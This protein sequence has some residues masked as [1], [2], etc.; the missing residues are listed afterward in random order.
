[1]TLNWCGLFCSGVEPPGWV[2]ELKGPEGK[3]AAGAS[4]ALRPKGG[5]S[6]VHRREPLGFLLELSSRSLPLK[7][8]CVRNFLEE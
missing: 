1:M 7:K 2:W 3:Q 8:K 5:W 4:R 6:H